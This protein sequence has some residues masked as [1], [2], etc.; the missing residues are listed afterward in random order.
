[1]PRHPEGRTALTVAER[2]VRKRARKARLEQQRLD[3]LRT[4]ADNPRVPAALRVLAL[5]ALKGNNP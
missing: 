3:A 2:S 1:M 4:I 5:D